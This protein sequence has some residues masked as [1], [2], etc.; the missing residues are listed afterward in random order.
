VVYHIAV[1]VV[2]YDVDRVS[3][4]AVRKR[5]AGKDDPVPSKTGIDLPFGPV[6]ALVR[7]VC[8]Y[9]GGGVLEQCRLD[10]ASV[11]PVLAH[12]Q[13][14]ADLLEGAKADHLRKG[15]A[16]VINA[17]VDEQSVE[18]VSKLSGLA[19]L[20]TVGNFPS[21]RDGSSGVLSLD[22]DGNP[23]LLREVVNGKLREHRFA[24]NHVDRRERFLMGGLLH[25]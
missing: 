15:L 22:V 20:L 8:G 16:L 21:K 7:D 12:V 18:L 13:L 2:Q 3:L 23:P 19:E 10:V 24:A 14:F 5:V 11:L 1:G 6:V 9:E 17:A 4:V 25:L